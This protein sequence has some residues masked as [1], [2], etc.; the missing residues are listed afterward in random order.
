MSDAR[1]T[2]RF[3]SLHIE[4]SGWRL[5]SHPSSTAGFPG[6]PSARPQWSVVNDGLLKLHGWHVGTDA[7]WQGA[8][9][10]GS[11]PFS[12][13]RNEM[14]KGTCALCMFACSMRTWPKVFSPVYAGVLALDCMDRS[15]VAS[16]DLLQEWATV[17]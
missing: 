1:I 16:V 2:T 7:A 5:T 13:E 15:K 8:F 12:E 11:Q 10:P 17:N 14:I 4:P 6:L 9:V 3:G